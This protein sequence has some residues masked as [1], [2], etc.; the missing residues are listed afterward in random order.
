MKP[1]PNIQPIKNDA[2]GRKQLVNA[3]LRKTTNKEWRAENPDGV[4]EKRADIDTYVRL[5]ILGMNQ[6]AAGRKIKL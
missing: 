6:R 4:A 5:T 1:A 3:I 2:E